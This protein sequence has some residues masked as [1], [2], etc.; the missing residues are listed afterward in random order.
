L[1]WIR[2]LIDKVHGIIRLFLFAKITKYTNR[3][4]VERF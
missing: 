1:N 2:I 3:K 4:I